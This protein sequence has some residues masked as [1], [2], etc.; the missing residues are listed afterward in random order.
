VPLSAVPLLVALAAGALSGC[1]EDERP[2]PRAPD[3]V[4]VQL[5]GGSTALA[6]E[7]ADE[8]GAPVIALE[9]LGAEGE[10]PLL[11]IPVPKG[12]RPE[13]LAAALAHQES[14]EFAE[15]VYLYQPQR[16]PRDPRYKDQWGLV[17]IE[18]PSAWSKTTGD[19]AVTVA[20]VDNGVEL[21]HPDLAANLWVNPDRAAGGE[22]EADAEGGAHGWNFVEHGADPG[23]GES[24]PERFHGSHVA[25]TIGAV[26]DNGAGVAGV[27]WSVSLMALRALGASGGRADDLARAIDFATDHGARVIE[28]AWSGAGTS[29]TIERAVE[30]ALHHGVLFVAAA[31]NEGALRP[32]FPASIDLE[33]VLSAAAVAPDGALAPFSNRAALVGAPGVGI[34]STTAPGIYERYDG[35]SMASAH[36]AGL[37]ALLWAARPEATLEQVRSAILSSSE[38][39]PGTRYG[40]IDAARA[41]DALAEGGRGARP[42]RLVLSRDRLVFNPALAGAPPPRSVAVR[43]E[44]GGARRFTIRTDAGWIRFARSSGITPSR[45][46]LSVDPT[47]A[48][49]GEREANVRVVPEGDEASAVQLTVALKPRGERTAL[50]AGAACEMRGRV[51]HVRRGT[52][53]RLTAPGF[54]EG[55]AAPG[56]SWQLPGGT[57]ARGAQLFA[58]FSR[59]GRFGLRVS[60]AS[61]G[62]EEVQVVVD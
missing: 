43:A 33:N 59:P 24:G 23:P 40:R 36:V 50:A 12:G 30:R 13:E 21:G 18:A 35:T 6:L 42:G 45:L 3:S 55:V 57:T 27:S 56:V 51:A 31:G 9:S 5:R 22:V 2:A 47:L 53:C 34:L 61:G 19:R 20:V 44:G 37:A 41:L 58:R 62:P 16:A 60:A 8:G 11:R 7:A 10:P 29:R 48:P 28:A 17:R 15:P 39:L 49:A 46:L 38:P 32:A 1:G 52:V 54:E 14:V 26:G 25:G 4:L